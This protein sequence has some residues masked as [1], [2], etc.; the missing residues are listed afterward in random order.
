[1]KKIT[2]GFSAFGL[3]FLLFGNVSM[4]AERSYRTDT[5]FILAQAVNKLVDN[6]GQYKIALVSIDKG[7][8]YCDILDVY[9]GRT[10]VVIKF[11]YRGRTR[12]TLSEF[13]EVNSKVYG[14]YPISLPWPIG[15]SNVR[16]ELKFNADGTANG[17]WENLGFK[18]K[19]HILKSGQQLD[20]DVEKEPIPQV[21]P[22]R[23]AKMRQKLLPEMRR[24]ARTPRSATRYIS[25]Y[26]E[27]TLE[28]LQPRCVF[29]GMEEALEN[30]YIFHR[31]FK[32]YVELRGWTYASW[33]KNLCDAI[34]LRYALPGGQTLV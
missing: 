20:P 2:Y 24:K 15:S 21:D 18:D 26:N 32:E 30:Y 27:D 3:I 9:K 17:Y 23:L 25:K 4:A 14:S 31:L 10:D 28:T 29:G 13:D 19:F 8:E 16:V 33:H 5:P 1:M 6:F 11:R 12:L 34:G 7:L 22:Q